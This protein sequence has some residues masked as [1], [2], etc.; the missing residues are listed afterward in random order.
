MNSPVVI[1][2][3]TLYLADCRELFDA[4]P[5]DAS[6]IMDPPYGIGY[7]H[8]GFH[9]GSIGKTGA[10]NKRGAPPV[11][12]DDAPFDPSPW[13]RFKN[14]LMW[15]ANHYHAR[16]PDSG[17]WLAW[18]KLGDMEPWDSFSDV[19][20]AWHSGRG[21][22]RIFSMKWKG[23][24]CD[25][26]GEANGLRQ[27]TTQKPIRLMRWCIE[28][29]ALQGTETIL[30]PYMGSGTTGIAAVQ[31]G[32]QFIGVEIHPPYFDIACQRI[33]DAQRQR[34]MFA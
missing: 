14:A 21:A 1:G 23:L 33:E 15:G 8:K 27:H 11:I 18:N 5:A 16:L 6:L 29:A 34:R 9:D 2:N 3:A 13:L 31:A 25:K 10:A 30:D 26:L 12:G 22:A 7:A 17:R 4:F 20:L 28:Q 24:A 19:E 32:H